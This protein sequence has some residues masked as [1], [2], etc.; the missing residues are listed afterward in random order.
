M[1]SGGG[2]AG[3]IY[4]ALALADRLVELGHDIMFVGTD[5][6]LES[7]L[8]ARAGIDFVALP[9]AGFN[10][11]KPLSFFTSGAMVASSS[12]KAK[13]LLKNFGAQAVIGFGGY[14][15]IPM[16]VAAS[17]THTPLIIHEQN[18]VAGMANNF[19]AKYASLV[20]VTYPDTVCAM[21]KVA[22]G[23]VIVTGNPVRKEILTANRAQARAELGLKEDEVFIFVFGGSRGAR[24]INAAFSSCIGELLNHG[25]VKVLHMTGAGEFDAVC[26]SLG[27]LVDDTRLTVRSYVENMGEVLAA[28]DLALCR[29]GATSIAELTALGV[30]SVLVP[31]PYA[32]GDHQ[33]KNAR[34][35]VD[36]GAAR[37]I[38]DSELDSGVLRD[39]LFELVDDP[40]LRRKMGQASSRLGGRNA[41]ELLVDGIYSVINDEK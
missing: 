28:T 14:V 32:T 21:E 26:E 37:L 41:T 17:R 16:G 8:V 24:H 19:L 4:P 1:L 27:D 35:L 18:S 30:P 22:K 13:K 31:Y 33:T 2:T 11:S 20:C 36:H 39:T 5:K 38:T 15:S 3:H 12:F 23:E 34:A 29:A 9:A 40:A 10:R 6:G 7:K 25:R